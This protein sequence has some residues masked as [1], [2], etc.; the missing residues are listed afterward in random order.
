MNLIVACNQKYVHPLRVMLTSFLESN[1]GECHSIYFLYSDVEKTTISKI[2]R[3][4]EQRYNCVFLPTA[5]KKSD[6]S[7]FPVSHHFS[8]ETYYRFLVQDVIPITENRV[9]WLDVDIIVRKSLKDFYSQDFEDK[10]LVV[11]KSINKQSQLLLDKLGCPEGSVYFNAGAILFNLNRLRNT[12]L[13]DYGLF[14]ERNK[15]RITWLDQDILNAMYA[16]NTKLADH[17]IYNMQ[18]FSNMQFS[19][20]EL[21]FIEENTAVVHFIGGVKPW[22]NGYDNPCIKYWKEYEGK[23]YSMW[24]K[25]VRFVKECRI[26]II[27]LVKRR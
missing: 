27:T 15:E 8:I 23:A 9:L 5:V 16:Q 25:T 12:A 21:Q 6:F 10:T 17:R 13:R 7:E 24:E 2:K 14:Y 20:E 18:M 11:C 3:F 22:H 19:N 26:K 4:L 1:K